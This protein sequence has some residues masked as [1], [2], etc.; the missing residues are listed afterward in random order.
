MLALR[1][2]APLF[3]RRITAAQARAVALCFRHPPHR[4]E[5]AVALWPLT[6]DRGDGGGGGAYWH[7]VG[8][9]ALFGWCCVLR[10]ARFAAFLFCFNPPYSFPPCLPFPPIYSTA[11][12]G[13]EQSAL[14]TR[15][16]PGA[17]FNSARPQPGHYVLDTSHPAHMEAARRIAAAAVSGGDGAPNIWNLRVRG[18]RWF[19]LIWGG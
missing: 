12:T 16:G 15:L 8:A 18:A 6:W 19:G 10:R 13:L 4:V 7:T 9:G 1:A 2:L 3:A 5:A 11:L 14:M 17:L